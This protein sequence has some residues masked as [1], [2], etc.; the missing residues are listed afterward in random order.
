MSHPIIKQLEK[1]NRKLMS[2]LSVSKERE[3]L[4]VTAAARQE[5]RATMVT[6][7]FAKEMQHIRDDLQNARTL[8]ELKNWLTE[9]VLD[10]W[11]DFMISASE[12]E[13]I[14]RNDWEKRAEALAD[15][16]NIHFNPE[17]LKNLSAQ[18]MQEYGLI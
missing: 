7:I 18:I 8:T 1:E 14:D 4:A 6:S 17:S 13:T 3:R 5:L 15:R 9:D 2:Q 10:K 11:S 16:A 12:L